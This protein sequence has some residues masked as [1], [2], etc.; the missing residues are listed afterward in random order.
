MA[1]YKKPRTDDAIIRKAAADKKAY[2]ELMQT[3]ET[4]ERDN[5]AEYNR[6]ADAH[7]KIV[8][9]IKAA[10]FYPDRV[11]KYMN[12]NYPDTPAALG[13]L[14]NKTR[15]KI[16]AERGRQQESQKRREYRYR[17]LTKTDEAIETLTAHGYVEL[18]DFM[19]H[20]A[21]SFLKSV[22]ETVEEPEGSGNLEKRIRSKMPLLEGGES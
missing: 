22:T 1:D 4:C 13:R 16:E 18:V 11:V 21:I 3:F 8:Q 20:R 15:A 6:R 2:D 19:P 17:W 5:I 10:G 14:K 12:Q 9:A 7:A